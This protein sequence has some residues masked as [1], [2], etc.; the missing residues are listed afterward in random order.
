MQGRQKFFE[1]LKQTSAN[2]SQAKGTLMAAALAY[3]ALFSVSP[4]LVLTVTLSRWILGSTGLIDALINRMS[5]FVPPAVADALRNLVE[6]YMTNAFSSFPAIIS[7]AVMLFGASIVFVQLKTALNQIWGLTTKPERN[8]LNFIRTQGLAFAAVVFLGVL[9]VTIT[10]STAILNSIRS[11]LLSETSFFNRAIP[12]LDLPLSAA[13]FTVI[14]ALL[15]K[16]LPDARVAWKDIWLGA[17][18]TAIAFTIG[19]SLL[20]FYLSQSNLFTAYG[21][22]SSVVVMMVWIYYSSQILL[23]GA[24]FTKTYADL[25]GS[26]LR[27][28]ASAMLVNANPSKNEPHSYE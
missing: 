2:F 16:I 1:L 23:F 9:L 6:S 20:A 7:V 19:E 8:V 24:A 4:L 28:N 15:F 11:N 22:A 18:A 26:K 21:V 17:L 25:Y 13:A 5:S 27:P 12:Y 10:F 3:Y 14:F